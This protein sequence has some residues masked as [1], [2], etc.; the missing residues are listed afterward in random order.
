MSRLAHRLQ[1]GRRAGPRCHNAVVLPAALLEYRCQFQQL[2]DEL[3][4][5][6]TIVVLAPRHHQVEQALTAPIERG[7]RADG[8]R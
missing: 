4:A 3:P 5:G 1:S 8:R 6:T 7:G 2:A